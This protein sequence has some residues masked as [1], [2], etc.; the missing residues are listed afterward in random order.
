MAMS[1]AAIRAAVRGLPIELPSWGF[2]NAGT[3]FGAFPEPGAAR[4]VFEKIEDAKAPAAT[5][6]ANEIQVDAESLTLL[7]V[8]AACTVTVVTDIHPE[9]NT[10]LEGL[11]KSGSMYCTQCEA[12]GFRHITFHPDRPDLLSRFRVRIEADGAS[13]LAAW[14]STGDGVAFHV[15]IP[16]DR[17]LVLMPRAAAA[18]VTAV[19]HPGGSIRDAQA[20]EVANRHHMAMIFT[21]QR[22][23]KH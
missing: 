4:D 13:A 8:P 21:H 22:H 18:G 5:F 1:H 2:A 9:T 17:S 15:G 10:A 14:T 12:E 7:D 19:I 20:I 3:R 16:G 23:F 11:Y 6:E